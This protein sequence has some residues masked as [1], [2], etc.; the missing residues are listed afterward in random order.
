MSLMLSQGA[1]YKYG[2]PQAS[3][4]FADAPSV[5]IKTVKRLTWAAELALSSSKF[6]KFVP[7]NELLSI[8]YFENTHIGVSR[9]L[10]ASSL[11]H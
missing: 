3:K 6:E 5:I 1:P 9:S 4:S 10:F 2:V 11:L 7:F 8:G